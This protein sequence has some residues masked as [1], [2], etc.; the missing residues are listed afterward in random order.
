MKKDPS[1]NKKPQKPG[2][3]PMVFRKPLKKTTFEKRFLKYIE[4]PQDNSFLKNCFE[5]KD[6]FYF[7]RG[8]LSKADVKKIKN[9]LKIIRMNRKGAV[10][11]IPMIF[12]AAI[13][14]AIA[15]FF[16]IFANPLL[17]KAVEIALESIF[18][19]KSEVDNFRLSLSKFE[20]SISGLTI[21]NRD[22]PMTNL[23]QMSK[24]G[25]KLKPQAVLRGKIFIEWVKADTIR[26]GTERKTSGAIEG[27]PKKE[28][29]AKEK[30]DAPPLIDL[31]NFNANDLLAQ[32]FDKLN[33]PKLYDEA[34]NA[35]NETSEKWKGNVEN[36]T[37]RVSELQSVSQP[38]LNINVSTLRDVETIRKTIQDV[39]A[40]TNAVQAA[41]NDVKTI[42]N[43]L[44]TDVNTAISLEQNARSSLENDINHLKS[45]IDLGSGAA[46]SAVEPFI[47]DMLSNTAEQYLDYGLMALDA[48]EKLKAQSASKPKESKPKKEKKITFKGRTVHYPTAAYPSFYLGKIASDF[49]LDSWNWMFDLGNISSDPD[50]TYRQTN[51][52]SVYLNL[53]LSEDGGVLN[54]N[55]A[56]KGTADFRT[57]PQER[58]SA[59]MTGNGFPVS[60]ADDLKSIGVNGFNGNADMAINLK[61][62]P[63]GSFS[64][65]GDVKIMQ[66]RVV[67][68]QGTI[69]QAIDTAV[70]EAGTVN[71]GIQYAHNTGRNDDFNL[72][73]NIA[74]LFGRALRSFVDSYAKK[75]MDDIENM[76]RQ[77]ID[78]Y[79]GD[80]FDSKESVDLLLKTVKGDSSAMDQMKSAL[81]AKKNEFE[82]R[83]NNMASEAANQATQQAE[84]TIRGALPSIP[85]I[86]RR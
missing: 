11:I 56:F 7:I 76:M 57:D 29:K 51:N 53:G 71:L 54:R 32:E 48:L 25:I 49:T 26:F 80:R 14:G 55:V 64:A 47:R 79:I 27:K 61:G 33:T 62:R 58:F 36:A 19:A 9:L 46:F 77:K 44:E 65:G 35:Y 15:V 34:I 63:D 66:P 5:K 70:R 40:A 72:T 21:A 38:L 83:L 85:G 78:E 86:P 17:E 84:Q 82:Q 52:S 20:I 3:P 45:Y 75:A 10:K 6:D 12:A 68:P 1:N 39:T 43:G 13:V 2:K 41:T 22:S 81:D 23:I 42:V 37:A 73:T 74:D 28:K 30:S 59:N 16:V 31:K 50:L 60:L 24:T 4:H 67:D 18:E 8:D 69:A